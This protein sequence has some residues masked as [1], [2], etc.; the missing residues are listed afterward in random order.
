M[1]E[2]RARPIAFRLLREAEARLV[3]S[4]PDDPGM[5]DLRRLRKDVVAAYLAALKETQGAA[6]AAAIA[7]GDRDLLRTIREEGLSDADAERLLG[8]ALG[9]PIFVQLSDAEALE[10]AAE[11]GVQGTAGVREMRLRRNFWAR[12]AGRLASR[13]VERAMGRLL[14]GETWRREAIEAIGK[15]L[16]TTRAHAALVVRTETTWAYAAGKAEVGFRTRGVT[17]FRFRGVSDKRQSDICRSR[18][19][20]I[21][22]ASDKRGIRRNSP[23]LHGHCRSTWELILGVLPSQKKIVRRRSARPRKRGD[24][25]YVPVP[26][27][28]RPTS[29][30]V[31]GIGRAQRSLIAAAG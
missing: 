27:G 3:E 8:R 17:H 25:G 28:W 31:A 14:M 21:W 2:R 16:K 24:K 22:K 4:L 30:N 26:K 13:R 19:G 10:A 9:E 11:A 23:P 6:F 20:K 1:V 15:A 7:D 18:T 29:A 5:P 12:K